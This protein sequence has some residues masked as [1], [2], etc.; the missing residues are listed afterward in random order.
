MT[1]KGTSNNNNGSVPFSAAYGTVRDYSSFFNALV[2]RQKTSIA[3]RVI[4]PLIDTVLLLKGK[5]QRWLHS[6]ASNEATEKLHV[7]KESIHSAF[8]QSGKYTIIVVLGDGLG[9][10]FTQSPFEVAVKFTLILRNP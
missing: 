1:S 10:C 2:P 9:R 7:D 5:P 4:V 3:P 8:R 6:S